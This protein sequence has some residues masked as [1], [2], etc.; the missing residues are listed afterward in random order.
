MKKLKTAVIG[1]GMGRWHAKHFQ[2]SSSCELVALSDQNPDAFGEW[3]GT[4]GAEN[5]Y[6]DYK[7][8]LAEKKPDLVSIA[9][10]NVLHAPVTMDAL[11]AG[12][13]VL[14]EKPMALNTAEAL[15]MQAL[16]EKVGKQ[17]A[18]N[19][20]YRY[21]PAA[22]A[23]HEYVN[24]G[25]LGEAYHGYTRWTRRDGFPRFG[26]WF[27]QQKLSGGGPL[28]DLG[29]HRIDLALWLMGLPE[30]VSV[31]GQAHKKI[32]VPRAAKA[33]A[34]FD[35]EDLATG[36]IR[37][38]NGASLVFEIS[39]AGHQKDGED[40]ETRIMGTEGTLIHRNIGGGYEFQ[41]EAYSTVNGVV[42]QSVLRPDASKCPNPYASVVD[43]LVEGR[44]VPVGAADGIRMQKILDA[45]Y[46][47]AALGREV[48]F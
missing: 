10:P 38:K 6:A 28:I 47:S 19:L 21:T 35:V 15:E 1:M 36:F 23:L 48:T 22:Y 33:G 17:I 16:A 18:I 32:G 40:M 39:W 45:L 3:K 11:K 43:A 31:S 42:T 9:L 2:E 20:S 7:A 8:M 30:P 24:A 27:G 41:A 25:F 5:C 4:L 44:P 29:V 26:G 37:F 34:T 46:E 12:A 13:H 14:C